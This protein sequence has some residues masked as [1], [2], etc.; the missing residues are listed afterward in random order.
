[1]CGL[2]RTEINTERRAPKALQRPRLFTCDLIADRHAHS[3]DKVVTVFEE[4]DTLTIQQVLAE[5]AANYSY[6]RPPDCSLLMRR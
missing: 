5:R 1:M 3:R 6:T 4:G 2:L